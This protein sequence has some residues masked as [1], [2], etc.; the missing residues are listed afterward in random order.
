MAANGC[1]LNDYYDYFRELAEWLSM[2]QEEI[3]LFRKKFYSRPSLMDYDKV[4][5]MHHSLGM[6]HNFPKGKGV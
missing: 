1:A 4:C 3:A 6:V 2:C 5:C